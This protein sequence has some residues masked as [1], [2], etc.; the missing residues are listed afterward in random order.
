MSLFDEWKK[1]GLQYRMLKQRVPEYLSPVQVHDFAVA[2]RT[3][4]RFPELLNPLSPMKR[5]YV[6]ALTS[7]GV[8]VLALRRP[9]VF[10]WK[11]S[12]TEYEASHEDASVVWDNDKLVIGGVTYFP[13]S[14]HKKD[15]KRIAEQFSG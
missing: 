4:A 14:F 12:D 8:S 7:K 13:I 11:I 9:G 15:A 1:G 10:S 3:P 5:E 2:V 6:I